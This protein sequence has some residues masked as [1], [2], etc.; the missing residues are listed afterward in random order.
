[1]KGCGGLISQHYQLPTK[2]STGFGDNMFCLILK[3]HL[4]GK[5]CRGKFAL[6]GK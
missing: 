3:V 5:Y 1:M 6:G 4:Y 2:L